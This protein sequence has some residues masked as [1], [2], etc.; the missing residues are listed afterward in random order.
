MDDSRS[1]DDAAELALEFVGYNKEVL[2]IGCSP[3]LAKLLAGHACSVIEVDVDDVVWHGAKDESFD[4]VILTEA[5]ANSP[6][7]LE[8]LSRAVHKLKPSGVLVSWLPNMAHGDTRT[9]AMEG[10]FRSGGHGV[11]DGPQVGSFTLQT[12]RDLFRRAGLV[13]VEMARVIVPLV[14]PQFGVTRDEVRPEGLHDLLEDPEIET[15][16]FVLRAVPDNGDQALVDLTRRFDEFADRARDETVRTALVRSELWQK[17]LLSLELEQHRKLAAEQQ[18]VIAEQQRY[19][20]ALRGHASG[21]E[22]NVEVLT[23]S[24]EQFRSPSAATETNHATRGRAER[25]TAPIHWISRKLTFG[26]KNS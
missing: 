10:Q 23:H 14:E 9:A 4:A 3:V 6:E 8:I 2:A 24:L 11:L 1:G 21:L 19:I 20:E 17:D 25:A 22:H 18:Q 13:I 7:P 12:I 5:L 15:Y 16:E 26:R